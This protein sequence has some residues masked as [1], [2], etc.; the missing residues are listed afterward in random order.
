MKISVSALIEP[1]EKDSSD[2]DK[3]YMLLQEQIDWIPGRNMVFLL[4]DF[5]A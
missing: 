1:T 5:S 3:F 2:L 4:G